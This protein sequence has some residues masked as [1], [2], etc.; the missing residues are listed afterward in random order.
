MSGLT[1][2]KN[3]FS[4]YFNKRISKLNETSMDT[5][6]KSQNNCCHKEHFY[7]LSMKF[8]KYIWITVTFMHLNCFNSG[9]KNVEKQT[10]F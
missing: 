4:K 2:E 3:D 1:D 7:K 6:D 10:I 9:T 5:C 8:L